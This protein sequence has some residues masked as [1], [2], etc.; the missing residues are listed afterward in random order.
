MRTILVSGAANGLGAAFV[1]AYRTQPNV[2]I[3][4][5]DRANHISSHDNVENLVVDVTDEK[6]IS[7]FQKDIQGHKTK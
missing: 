3:I 2:H 5:I 1:E 6:S 4:A 7:A